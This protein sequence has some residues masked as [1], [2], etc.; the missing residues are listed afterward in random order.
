MTDFAA[1]AG[2]DWFQDKLMNFFVQSLNEMIIPLVA[3]LSL[4][5]SAHGL[6]DTYPL[7]PQAP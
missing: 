4:L 3:S 5:Y 1:M 2:I 6:S 7:K